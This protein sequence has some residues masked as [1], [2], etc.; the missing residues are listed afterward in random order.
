MNA[1]RR[2]KIDAVFSKLEELGAALEEIRDEEQDFYDNLSEKAQEGEKG[3]K[4][5]CAIDALDEAIDYLENARDS[6]ENAKEE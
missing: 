5:Q 4:S 6:L 3:E 1:A 2:K